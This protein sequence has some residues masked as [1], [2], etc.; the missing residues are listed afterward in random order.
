MNNRIF[1]CQNWICFLSM[2][3]NKSINCFLN[4]WNLFVHTKQRHL[5][6]QF[7]IYIIIIEINY[8]W[9]FNQ[10]KSTNCQSYIDN[11]FCAKS[12]RNSTTWK[13]RQNPRKCYLFPFRGF[14]RLEIT[15]PCHYSCLPLIASFIFFLWFSLP[16]S[17]SPL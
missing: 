8:I 14:R 2:Y 11:T 4:Y 15:F 17:P 9:F 1:M 12:T 7:K 6:Y 3:N 5:L 16:S 10:I 13:K